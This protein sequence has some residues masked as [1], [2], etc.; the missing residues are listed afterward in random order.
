MAKEKSKSRVLVS[1][2]AGGAVPVEDRRFEQGPWSIRFEVPGDRADDWFAHL[3]AE[4]SKNS[5]WNQQAVGQMSAEENSGTVYLNMGTVGQSS[6]IIIVW[7]RQRSGPMLIRAR[8]AG[9]PKPTVKLARA[10]LQRISD[11]AAKGIKE[12]YHR[13]GLLVLLRFAMAGRTAA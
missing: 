6:Q 4:C 11:N 13:G 5:G 8:P 3:Q 7:E 9:K 12:R 10:I 1:D 2:G